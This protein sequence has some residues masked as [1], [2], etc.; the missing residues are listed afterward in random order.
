MWTEK[1]SWFVFKLVKVRQ[2]CSHLSVRNIWLETI[3]SS[4][5]DIHTVCPRRLDPFHEVTYNIKCFETAW[6]YGVKHIPAGNLPNSK[7]I[8][9]SLSLLLVK[10][11]FLFPCDPVCLISPKSPIRIMRLVSAI[12]VLHTRPNQTS[13]PNQISSRISKNSKSWKYWFFL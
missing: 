3:I 4:Y 9:N 12:L 5:H 10:N 7:L 13:Q 2:S 11:R 8:N 1:G 6:A